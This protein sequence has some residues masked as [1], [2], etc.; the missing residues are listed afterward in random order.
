[1]R[2][3]FKKCRSENLRI[4]RRFQ[5]AFNL[6]CV[7][8]GEY[9]DGVVA[10]R[11]LEAS[12]LERDLEAKDDAQID[13]LWNAG[14]RELWEAKT[15]NQQRLHALNHL[16]AARDTFG[17]GPKWAF[18]VDAE[19]ENYVAYVDC[20]LA[21]N[22]VPHGQAN[23]AY[24]AHPQFRGKGYV[25]RAVRQV[26]LFLKENTDA[27]EAHINENIASLRVALAVGAVDSGSWINEQGRLM[28]RFII[29]VR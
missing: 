6:H 3:R 12:D 5:Q 17:D 22:H 13:W 1:V 26:L 14:D 21:N 23:I 24:S 11:R 8:Q 10:I 2:R 28:T 25:S 19:G 29:E 4:I 7:H 18:A 20:D 9:S 16:E 27:T 15:V